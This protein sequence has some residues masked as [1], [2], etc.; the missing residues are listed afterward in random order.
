MALP[1]SLPTK[2]V[3]VRRRLVSVWL[4]GSASSR[5][6]LEGGRREAEDWALGGAPPGMGARDPAS[7]GP[8]E[9]REEA[10]SMLRPW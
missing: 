7:A 4:R 9:E 3:T 1:L 8:R 6:W 2:L 5:A 10:C